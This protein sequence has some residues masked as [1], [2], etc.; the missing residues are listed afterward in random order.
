MTE[1]N[2]R[3]SMPP[4]VSVASSTLSAELEAIFRAFPDQLL[5]LDATGSILEYRAGKTASLYRTPEEI[6]GKHIRDILPLQ[7][8]EKIEGGIHYA[9]S[10]GR[11]ASVNYHLD[12]P[13]GERWY[14]GRLVALEE[15]QVVAVIRDITEHVQVNEKV[16]RQLQQLDSLHSID[17]AITSSFDL[18]VTLSVILRQVIGQLRVDAAD[19]LLLDPST[20]RLEFAAGQGFQRSGLQL[21]PLTVGQGYAGIAAM[22]KR[23]VKVPDLKGRQT[24]FLSSPSFV[25]EGFASYYAVPLIAKGQARGVLEIYNRSPLKPAEDWFE[26]MGTLAGQAA[27]AIDSASLFQE[28]QRSNTDLTSAYEVAIHG[29]VEALE[30]SGRE[31]SG[32]AARVVDKSVDLGYHMGM[33]ETDLIHLRRGAILHD[34]GNLG[35]PEHLLNKPGPLSD[36]EWP[37]VREHPR[38]A[39]QLLSPMSFLSQAIDIPH[40]HHERWD[41]TGYP[42]GMRG[43]QI[44]QTARLFSVVDVYDSM[45]HPRPYRPAW[46]PAEAVDYIRHQ[47]GLH[48]DPAVVRAFLKLLGE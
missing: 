1:T 10:T 12:L 20:R 5:R 37:I 27:I 38:I 41:G 2:R 45:T 4:N 3:T 18:Q 24:D 39:L 15:T 48:F 17:A 8:S 16:K 44:P 14:E 9:I 31:T 32:H 28:L 11:I 29:W 40:Y 30:L 13:E 7:I 35:V 36:T 33:S 42:D 22:E 34:I 26:F 25:Q 19:V 6:L 46:N 47:V 23:T 43:E 21:V